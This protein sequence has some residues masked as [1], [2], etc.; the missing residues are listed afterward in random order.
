MD[1]YT[2]FLS[3]IV[4]GIFV[5]NLFSEYS[6]QINDSSS[7]ERIIPEI[8]G[9]SES[10]ILTFLK[11]QAFFQP[12]S[13]WF[14][15]I[16]GTPL[17]EHYLGLISVIVS[18]RP[19]LQKCL[20]RC[21]HCQIPFFSYPCNAGRED[22]GCPFGCRGYHRSENSRK[23]STEFYRSKEGKAKKRCLNQK[24]C[25]DLSEETSSIQQQA[26]CDLS[27]RINPNEKPDLEP[28]TKTL[29]EDTIYLQVVV[30]LIEGRRFSMKEIK[31]FIQKIVRQLSLYC[32][33]ANGY[34]NGKDPN[35]S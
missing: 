12:V 35:S 13:D 6:P 27:E 26:S 17:I 33:V 14:Q 31:G 4:Q 2:S 19:T 18:N 9:E 15:K 23:R 5:K 25:L 7:N 21:K 34:L 32:S 10:F 24:R 30:G 1:K 22:L 28:Q 3:K 8:S 20:V 16:K 11:I 29:N